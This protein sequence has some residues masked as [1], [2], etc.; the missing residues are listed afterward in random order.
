MGKSNAKL[1]VGI[2]AV[3]II[4][5]LYENSRGWQD[6]QGTPATGSIANNGANSVVTTT[7]VGGQGLKDGDLVTVNVNAV[8][9]L[10]GGS[11]TEATNTKSVWLYKS[12]A[13]A[14]TIQ[15]TG[16]AKTIK[17]SADGKIWA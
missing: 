15:T 7:T 16:T 13:G 12:A 17:T 6:L 14:F 11:Y 10:T 1:Y 8:D 9:A 5:A 4:G 3:L 2:L